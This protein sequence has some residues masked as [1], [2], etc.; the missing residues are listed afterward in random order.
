[1]MN[2]EYILIDSK[3][4]AEI[5]YKALQKLA[6]NM[7]RPISESSIE[8]KAVIDVVNYLFENNEWFDI[9]NRSSDLISTSDGTTEWTTTVGED[10]VTIYQSKQKKNE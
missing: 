1:M 2:K 8:A 7:E 9:N 10:G 3:K 5:K 4:I 6:A